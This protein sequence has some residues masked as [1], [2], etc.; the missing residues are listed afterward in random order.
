MRLL[1]QRDPEDAVGKGPPHL[2]SA[3]QGTGQHAL[4]DPAHPLQPNPRRR[5]AHHHWLLQVDQKQI[6]QSLDAVRL[7][8]EASRQLGNRHQLA[9]RRNRLGEL[10]DQVGEVRVIVRVVAK[11]LSMKQLEVLGNQL[12]AVD[13]LTRVSCS[14]GAV[15]VQAHN[16][17]HALA[18]LEVGKAPF[19]RDVVGGEH[20][21]ADDQQQPVARRNSIANLL[22]K[23]ELPRGHGDAVKP[24]VKP[25]VSQ[26]AVQPANKRLIVIASIGKEY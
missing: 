7:R 15:A 23:R 2:G 25:S 26:I 12:V 14:V 16:R 8:Q 19:L 18:G 20:A 13:A 24:D 17:V 1:A 6:A 21:W 5:A 11:V 22:V 10:P 9:H 4:A 3:G